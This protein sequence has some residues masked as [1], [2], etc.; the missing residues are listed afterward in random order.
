MTG[1]CG[2]TVNPLPVKWRNVAFPLDCRSEYGAI[3]ADL[4][5][6]VFTSG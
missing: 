5:S 6:E 1:I 3:R 4:S 2:G